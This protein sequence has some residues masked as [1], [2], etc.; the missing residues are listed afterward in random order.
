LT[1]FAAPYDQGSVVAT[2][3][4]AGAYDTADFALHPDPHGG[5]E[6]A[7]VGAA[8]ALP[9]DFLAAS[10]AGRDVSVADPIEA[11][12]GWHAPPTASLLDIYFGYH[13]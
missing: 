4:F 8:A 7:F 6:I 11:A 10:L 3:A 2:L 9:P 12:P 13:I 5:T 1:L